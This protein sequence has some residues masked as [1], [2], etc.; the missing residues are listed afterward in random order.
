M[1]SEA[2]KLRR[3]LPEHG[4]GVTYLELVH[5]DG[6]ARQHIQRRLKRRGLRLATYQQVRRLVVYTTAKL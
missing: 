1:G 5:E 4:P 2:L 3:P 6:N